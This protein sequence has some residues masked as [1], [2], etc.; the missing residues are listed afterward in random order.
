MQL[1]GGLLAVLSV[2]TADAGEL[3]A[4]FRQDFQT[5]YQPQYFRMLGGINAVRFFE[6]AEEGGLRITTFYDEQANKQCGVAPRV[7]IRG[8]FEITLAYQFL[9]VPE[10]PSGQKAGVRVSIEGAN[11][12]RASLEHARIRRLG[13]LFTA[14]RS[15]QR[16]GKHQWTNEI[17]LTEATGGRL[18][19][20]RVDDRLTFLVAEGE[21]EE[22]VEL[23]ETSFPR[24]NVSKVQFM[25]DNGQSAEPVDVLWNSLDIRCEKVTLGER[26]PTALWALILTVLVMGLLTLVLLVRL[27]RGRRV[28]VEEVTDESP[29]GD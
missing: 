1:I 6:V 3:D 4:Q 21:D 14:A 8:D 20:K 17:Q 12:E 24:D 9:S 28:A 26:R 2:A 15:T 18:R 16:G 5:E 25:V 22:F 29:G 23:F 7:V 27:S 11:K 10:P 13:Y 19:L